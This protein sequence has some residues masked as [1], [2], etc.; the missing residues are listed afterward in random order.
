MLLSAMIKSWRHSEGLSL[1]AVAKMTGVTFYTL[2]RLETGKVITH[3]SLV[4]LWLW[5]LKE[6]LK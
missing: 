5:M 2:H 4:K 3:K 1:R 6:E